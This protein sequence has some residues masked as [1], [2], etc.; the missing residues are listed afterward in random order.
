MKSKRKKQFD[1]VGKI[2][3]SMI[4]GF[5]TSYIALNLLSD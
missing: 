4:G 2:T 3:L 5:L 1:S